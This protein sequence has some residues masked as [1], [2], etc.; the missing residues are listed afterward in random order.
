MKRRPAVTLPQTGAQLIRLR[1]EDVYGGMVRERANEQDA[2]VL[3]LAA[4]IARHG[5]LSPVVVRRNAQ[6]GRY[7]LVCGARRVLAC[8]LLSMK[9][10]DAIVLDADEAAAAACFLEEHATRRSV[11]FLDEAQ[12]IAR[13]GERRM[14]EECT[15]D[16][17]GILTRL[18]LMRQDERVCERMRAGGLS[19]RQAVPLLSIPDTQRQIEAADIIAGRELTPGQA[20]RLVCGPE[21]PAQEEHGRRRLLRAATEAAERTVQMLEHK[22]LTSRV[23]IQTQEQGI[24]IQILLKNAQNRQAQQENG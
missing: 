15:L 9:E 12:I 16:E 24:C 6:A 7:A 22:G 13:V 20:R 17:D 14:A 1:L 4:S 3:M 5:L 11:H 19:I 18:K 10:I 21:R 8:R 2:S 23:N